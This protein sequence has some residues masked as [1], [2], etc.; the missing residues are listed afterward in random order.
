MECQQTLKTDTIKKTQPPKTV[1]LAWSLEHCHIYL[2]DNKFT[3]IAEAKLLENIYN[4]PKSK[5]YDL[6]FGKCACRILFKPG[7]SNMSEYLSR[8]P[9]TGQGN[10]SS[11]AKENV[12][13][14]AYHDVLVAINMNEI[15]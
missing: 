13:F 1:A 10:K 11:I 3:V 15:I 8:H 6:N 5:L 2:F 14:L 7:E 9:D 12:S 4:N